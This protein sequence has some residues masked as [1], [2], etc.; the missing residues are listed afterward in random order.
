MRI[1]IRTEIRILP[2]STSAHPQI[3]TSADPHIRILPPAELQSLTRHS[4]PH[5]QRLLTYL[6]KQ[7]TFLSFPFFTFIPKIYQQLHQQSF[8]YSH[9]EYIYIFAQRN[10]IVLRAAASTRVLLE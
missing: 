10:T 3:R 2:V 5:F 4:I 1:L 6:H 9:I 7:A 8:R